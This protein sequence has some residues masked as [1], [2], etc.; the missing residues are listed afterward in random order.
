MREY[1]EA[2]IEERRKRP[3]EADILSGVV[4]ARD[5]G[6]ITDDELWSLVVSLIV[7]GHGTT[8]N[9]IGLGVHTLLQHRDQLELIRGDR[10]WLQN[11]AEEI[12][13][14]EPS[15]DGPARIA[16][17]TV[18]IAGVEISAEGVL[19]L[20]LASANRDS[21]MF[22]DGDRFD[23]T[24][25]NANRHLTFSAGIHRCLGAP[26]A[27]LQIPIAL[28]ALLDRLEVMEPAGE[29]TLTYSTF[30]GLSSLPLYVKRRDA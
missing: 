25:R 1:V 19:A 15:L 7:A 26:L 22:P 11:A 6:E 12:L 9:T 16:N 8:A 4:A 5:Q 21:R 10:A 3:I 13:R 2:A 17:Q 27:Q 20:S 14:Y 18:E 30:R 28:D 23:V 29:P 24:R